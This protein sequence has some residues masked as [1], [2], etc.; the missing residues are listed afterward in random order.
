MSSLEL[1]GTSIALSFIAWGL[2][3]ASSFWPELRRRPRATALRSLLLLHAFRFVGLAFVVPGVVS[4]ELP[5]AWARPAAY[6]DLIAA[7]LAL[8][9]LAGLRSR[10]GLALVWVFNL[11]GTTDLL[12]AFYRGN[13]VGLNPGHLGAGF[14][15]LTVLVPL[16]LITHA[17]VFWL[18]LRGETTASAGTVQVGHPNL[19]A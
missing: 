7:L 10:L 2:V 19:R 11:W 15:I 8:L 1:F 17:L 6:G 13:A 4:P 18:L 3:A 14:F 9:A 12:Y 5:A 16:L